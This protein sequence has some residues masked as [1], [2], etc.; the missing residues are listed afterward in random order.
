MQRAKHAAAAANNVNVNVNVNGSSSV[1]FSAKAKAMKASNAAT[2][3]ALL[4]VVT[5]SLTSA[6]SNAC[7]YQNPGA[8]VCAD[9]NAYMTCG[10]NGEVLLF[11]WYS[12]FVIVFSSFYVGVSYIEAS[13]R[14]VWH[15]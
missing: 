8:I 12:L 4:L 15:I 10:Y 3:A 5:A 6:A 9:L 13:Q 14:E 2:M 11:G 1:N 7:A